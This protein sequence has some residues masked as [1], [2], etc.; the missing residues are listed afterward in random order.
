M[1]KS[2]KNFMSQLSLFEQQINQIQQQK[3]AVNQAIEEMTFLDKGLEELIGSRDK[4]ILSQI[5][6]GIFVK[7]KLLSEEL[8]VNIGEKNFVKKSISE[9]KEIISKQIEKLKEAQEDLEKTTEEI[10]EELER[11][12]KEAILQKTKENAVEK[13][14]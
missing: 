3:E 12:M 8:L 7:S 10:S 14:D 9:T 4:E 11:T 6:N 2:E 5:G 1:E 13:K